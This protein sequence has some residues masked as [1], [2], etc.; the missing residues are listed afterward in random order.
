LA[1]KEDAVLC[2]FCRRGKIQWRLEQIA[3]RQW[4]DKGYVHCQI[5]LP[6]GI[7]DKCGGR[8]LPP[9]AEK[10]FDGEFEGRYRK[11]L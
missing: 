9:H 8:T 2:E 6:M 5:E 4:S 11:L 10:I 3:F 1:P 7:C